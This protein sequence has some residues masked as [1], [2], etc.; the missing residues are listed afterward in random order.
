MPLIF[1][2]KAVVVT[3][4][5]SGIGRAT[6]LAFAQA[7]ARV[8]VA[9]L[10]AER[11]EA[12]AQEID[13]AGGEALAVQ[14]DV[15]EAASV[16][17]MVGEVEDALGRL[18]GACNIAGIE[19]PRALTAELDE[20]D[21]DRVLRVDLKGVWL[22]MKH[23]LRLMLRQ[24]GGGGAIV[25]VASAFG[26]VGFRKRPAYVAAKHG[27]V[28]LTKAAALEYAKAG[29]RVN[30][31]CPSFIDTPMQE[32]LGRVFHPSAF[33]EATRA[34]PMERLGRPDEVAQ[35][36]LWLASDAASF[37]TGQALSVDGG[38]TAQ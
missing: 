21:W 3:G 7:G 26:K 6:A 38:Y 28:G 4:A 14:V 33:D 29:I 24:E 5:G 22:C 11:A 20:A 30:A 27:V 12:T 13:D 25:N 37:V 31:V 17:A 23:E 10:D 36:I 15:S 18:D 34:Y 35:A 8:A 32:R 19:S 9:D 2:G 1:D 16:A